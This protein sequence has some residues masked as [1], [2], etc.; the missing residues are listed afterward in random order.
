MELVEGK[1]LRDEISYGS[2][3]DAEDAAD[4]GI[5]L[6]EA[7][8]AVHA[9]GVIHGDIKA[10]NVIREAGGRIVLMDF[11]AARLRDPEAHESKETLAGTKQYM[12]PE[13]FDLQEPTVQSDVYALG[14]LLFY[15][16]TG[17][18]PVR[19]DTAEEIR[20]AHARGER[21]VTLQEANPDLP[22][23]FAR[24][25]EQ[26]LART[27]TQRWSG[28]A[29]M[30]RGLAESKP[31]RPAGFNRRRLWRVAVA[32]V[33]L[34]P[35]IV[36]MGF[37]E[38]RAFEV[39]LH[40]PSD[41]T[42]RP[43]SYFMAGVTAL[44]PFFFMWGLGGFMFGLLVGLLHGLRRLFGKRMESLFRRVVEPID[45][46]DPK[47]V[48]ATVLFLGVSVLAWSTWAFYDPLMSGLVAL[49][50][51]PSE[52]SSHLAL[53]DPEL[54]NVHQL[55]GLCA[56]SLSLA[57]ALA[58]W[59]W[60]P[61]LERRVGDASTVRLIKWA[62]VVV[63]FVAVALTMTPRRVL[64]DSFEIAELNGTE[65]YVVGAT[66]N[67]LLLYDPRGIDQALWRVEATDSAIRRLG[68]SRRLN[69]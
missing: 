28:V 68:S 67:Q 14:V 12:A 7:L 22:E 46:V 63:G 5:A 27:P 55:W 56:A 9:A 52:S 42:V 10:Q 62:A 35:A 60:F 48:A 15:L 1:T 2:N 30:A 57:L 39:V 23:P 38:S 61:H 41:F 44:A 33:A 25:V 36:A 8:E 40:V 53:F 51:G 16:V 24:V 65:M 18:H 66:E 54:R 31:R 64:W 45:A 13:L 21:M 47:V 6:C 26:A 29:T 69:E 49:Y 17:K 4:I 34:V 50:L 20:R 3:L 11:G 58:A 19:G 43:A 37:V 59:R 32:V